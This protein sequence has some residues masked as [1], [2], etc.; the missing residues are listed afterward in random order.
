MYVLNYTDDY[1]N[2]INCTNNENEHDNINIKFLFL[3]VSSS[4][5]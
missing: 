3:S 5:L 2:F 4:I 1:D